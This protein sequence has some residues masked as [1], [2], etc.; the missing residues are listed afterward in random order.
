VKR[1]YKI[2]AWSLIPLLFVGI[3]AVGLFTL[4]TTRARA[5]GNGAQTVCD[6]KSNE[7]TY[8]VA[9]QNVTVWKCQL[10]D[11]GQPYCLKERPKPDQTMNYI[12]CFP[13][14]PSGTLLIA[15]Q[16][17]GQNINGSDI[18]DEIANTDA[19][20]NTTYPFLFVSDEFMVTMNQGQPSPV[21][22]DCKTLPAGAG[23]YPV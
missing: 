10:I 16:T 20:T 21:I 13:Y 15:C 9:G 5:F 19:K 23:K 3:L 17:Q 18:W 12:N 4:H 14:T 11:I 7:A 22:P 1:H 8:P 6:Q 2:A